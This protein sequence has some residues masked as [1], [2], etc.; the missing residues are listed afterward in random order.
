MSSNIMEYKGVCKEYADKNASETGKE[1][2]SKRFRAINII[3]DK[4]I[5]LYPDTSVTPKDIPIHNHP[6][7]KQALIN[8]VASIQHTDAY[9]EWAN[10]V[11]IR[12]QEL[13]LESPKTTYNVL[14]FSQQNNKMRKYT[15]KKIMCTHMEAASQLS[16]IKFQTPL[17]RYTHTPQNPHTSRIR[18]GSSI[19]DIFSKTSNGIIKINNHP[20]TN[21]KSY[22]RL[23]I[24][25]HEITH[26]QIAQL[27]RYAFLGN[28]NLPPHL[29]HLKYDA[30]IW[31]EKNT[32]KATISPRIYDI[33]QMQCHEEIAR[34]QQ[35]KFNSFTQTLS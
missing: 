13:I 23:G 7:A 18:G 33:Y 3:R 30:Q 8:L 26:D 34:D 29:T 20:A 6:D 15:E 22:K 1:T 35:A 19:R 2:L 16:G 5:S 27:A 28:G 4:L 9:I 24:C 32:H 25:L 10:N 21:P 12:T 14:F 17:I 11:R 31:L